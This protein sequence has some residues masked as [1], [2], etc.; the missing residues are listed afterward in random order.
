MNV[1]TSYKDGVELA[2]RIQLAQYIHVSIKP[3]LRYIHV[4]D[5]SIFLLPQLA[6]KM[7]TLVEGSS[8]R[9]LFLLLPLAL[10]T[11]TLVE[12]SSARAPFHVSDV[13]RLFPVRSRVSRRTW[14]CKCSATM[15]RQKGKVGTLEQLASWNIYTLPVNNMST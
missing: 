4:V 5:G 12:G 9:A 10:I 11:R 14:R 13:T 15:T 6:F 3:A 1:R 8:A 2:S 7:R